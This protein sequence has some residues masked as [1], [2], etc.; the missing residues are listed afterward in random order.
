MLIN[1]DNDLSD[2]RMFINQL[3]I[4]HVVKTVP[5]DFNQSVIT[6]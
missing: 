3:L 1:T 6:H 2:S 5:C 4:R